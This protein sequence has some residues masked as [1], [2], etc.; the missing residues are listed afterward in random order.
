MA[1]RSSPVSGVAPDLTVAIRPPS[2][3]ILTSRAQPSGS[4]AFSK[5]RCGKPSSEHGPRWTALCACNM[6]RQIR[7]VPS[8]YLKD[9]RLSIVMTAVDRIWHRCRL[10]TLAPERE[11]LGLID[12][13]LI[14]AKDGFIIYAGAN[15]GEIGRAH[16]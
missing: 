7:D 12:D 4:N 1:W 5:H 13:G 10:A 15:A 11:G 16:V 14:A 3:D 6:Y 9:S 8:V 2:I